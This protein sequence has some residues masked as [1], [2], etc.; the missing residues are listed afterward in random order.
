MT[1]TIGAANRTGRFITTLTSLPQKPFSTSSRVWVFCVR[2][3]NQS[4]ILR[5]NWV[6]RRN[7]IR[8]SVRTPSASTLRPRMLSTAGSTV[9]DRIADNITD[10]IP[11]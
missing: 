6:L 8:Y 1:M 5:M 11:A 4:M 3:T 9:I 7:G 2:S 10:A